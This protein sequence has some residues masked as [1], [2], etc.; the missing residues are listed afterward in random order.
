MFGLAACTHIL[1]EI[2]GR[3]YEPLAIQ[4]RPRV[5]EKLFREF[6]K[7]VSPSNEFGTPLPININE[8]DLGYVLDEIYANKSVLPPHNNLSKPVLVKWNPELPLSIRNVAP[9]ESKDLEKH[10]NEVI[11]L[12][13]SPS[14]VW[15]KDA[16][17][18]FNKKSKEI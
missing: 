10:Q 15:S 6:H 5:Y 18:Y 3:Q 13:Q 8:T 9:I 11:K 2:S 17:E 16:D 7:R 12:K 14:I 4:N 1:L